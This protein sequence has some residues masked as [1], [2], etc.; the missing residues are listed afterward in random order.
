[1]CV[2]LF[3]LYK[4][5]NNR[6]A[7]VL[8]SRVVVTSGLVRVGWRLEGTGKSLLGGLDCSVSLSR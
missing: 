8:D 3:H 6:D 1:M 4:I 7:V 5:Q 2:L